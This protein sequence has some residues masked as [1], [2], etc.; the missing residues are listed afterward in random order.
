[1]ATRTLFRNVNILD[2]TGAPPFAGSAL[3]EGNRI[4][5]PPTALPWWTAWAR[6]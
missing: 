5:A 1:M 2:C 6:P 3:I 4:K